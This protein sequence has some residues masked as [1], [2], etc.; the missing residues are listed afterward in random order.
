MCLSSRYGRGINRRIT[1][2]A[3]LKNADPTRTITKAKM[4][5]HVAKLVEHLP[6]KHKVL[7]SNSSIA[8]DYSSLPLYW[9]KMEISVSQVVFYRSEG[10]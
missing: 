9:N 2:Q 1:V 3:H 6:S 4:A 10:F 8:K 5:G 7:S